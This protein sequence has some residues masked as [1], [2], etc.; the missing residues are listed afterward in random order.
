MPE[1]RTH[2]NL[3]RQLLDYVV[4]MEVD[5]DKGL[6]FV[7]SPDSPRQMK[8]PLING[9]TPDLYARHPR[10][11]VTLIGE[12]KT[13][14]DLGSPHTERQIRGFLAK[15]AGEAS[16]LFILAVPWDV[17]PYARW[18]LRTI[19]RDTGLTEAQTLVLEELEG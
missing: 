19:Q 15:C 10:T 16:S 1:S 8:P 4:Q 5:G 2:I 11:G 18:L 13:A 9:F 7:D 6:V 3:V 17:V 14:S 12:A